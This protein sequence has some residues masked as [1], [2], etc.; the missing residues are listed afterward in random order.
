MKDSES[1]AEQAA[2]RMMQETDMLAVGQIYVIARENFFHALKLAANTRDSHE[3]HRIELR[4]ARLDADF[5]Q[6]FPD[7]DSA[8]LSEC[9][10][11]GEQAYSEMYDASNSTAAAGHYNNA[12]DYFSRAIGSAQRIGQDKEARRLQDRLDHIRAV[13]RGQFS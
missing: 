10:A 13:F 9:C 7:H 5:L 4:I 12:K 11:R 1:L 3:K 8:T 2:S 6:L